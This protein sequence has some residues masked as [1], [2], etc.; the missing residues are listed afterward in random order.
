MKQNS[1]CKTVC[2]QYNKSLTIFSCH[3]GSQAIEERIRKVEHHLGQIRRGLSTKP[4]QTS[5]ITWQHIG[6]AHEIFRVCHHGQ[7]SLGVPN[8]PHSWPVPSLSQAQW[9][10]SW[11]SRCVLWQQPR[12]EDSQAQQHPERCPSCCHSDS[13]LGSPRKERDLLPGTEARPGDVFNSNWTGGRGTALNTIVINSLQIS[14][15]AKAAT[16][17]GIALTTTYTRK[18]TK[19]GQACRREGIKFVPMPMETLGGWHKVTTMQVKKQSDVT[20][21]LYQRMAVILAMENNAMLLN[22]SPASP[23]THHDGIQWTDH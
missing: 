11:R 1:D 18:M 3:I 22:R 21:Q 13:L 9:C 15:V 10:S 6:T 4:N 2:K 23:S 12:G 20:R 17:P 7:Y 19:V 5:S 14:H 16:T 8:L